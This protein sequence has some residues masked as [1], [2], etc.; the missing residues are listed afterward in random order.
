M[1]LRG[2]QES[3]QLASART[4]VRLYSSVCHSNEDKNKHGRIRI[5]LRTVLAMVHLTLR[6][7]NPHG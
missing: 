5:M 6:K 1:A 7:A 4:E 2:L 3:L